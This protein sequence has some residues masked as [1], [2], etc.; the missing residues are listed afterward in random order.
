MVRTLFASFHAFLARAKKPSKPAPKPA[1]VPSPTRPARPR[2]A[3]LMASYRRSL[4][5]AE[6]LDHCLEAIIATGGGSC[7]Q[8][9][10]LACMDYK[11]ILKVYET[12]T[13]EELG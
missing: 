11:R 3:A 10:Q 8:A 7:P 1:P 6:W 2:H 12:C 9:F 13:P 4:R 5:Q